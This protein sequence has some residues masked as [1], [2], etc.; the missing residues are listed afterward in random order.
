MV[1]NAYHHSIVDKKQLKFETKKC[2]SCKSIQTPESVTDTIKMRMLDYKLELTAAAWSQTS[3]IE[4]NKIQQNI[5]IR[6]RWEIS[7]SSF[8]GFSQGIRVGRH[9]N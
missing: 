1:I 4:Y 8:T 5:N 9:N 2:H 7:D 3:E 6:C